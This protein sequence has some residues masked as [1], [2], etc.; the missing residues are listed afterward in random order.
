MLN[1]FLILYLAWTFHTSVIAFYIT[2]AFYAINR[3]RGLYSII[4]GYA[5]NTRK[6]GIRLLE[7][8]VSLIALIAIYSAASNKIS[9]S[10]Y[11]IR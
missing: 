10:S 5:L 4:Q 2:I 11:M 7:P 8:V 1:M 3:A 9:I 6:I